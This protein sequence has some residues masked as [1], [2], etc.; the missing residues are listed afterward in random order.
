MN[1]STFSAILCSVAPCLLAAAGA[2]EPAQEGGPLRISGPISVEEQPDPASAFQ[3]AHELIESLGHFPINLEFESQS[4]AQILA[5]T[6]PQDSPEVIE[7]ERVEQPSSNGLP[8]GSDAESAVAAPSEIEEE[9]EASAPI[10]ASELLPLGQS[11]AASADGKTS[12]GASDSN[13]GSIVRTVGATGM[14]IALILLL[15]FAFVKLSGTSGG[16]RAQLGAAGKAPSGVLFVLGRFPISRGMSLVLLQLD[17]RVLLL[18]QTGE[19]FQTLAELTDPD[20]VASIIRKVKD[21]SGESLTAKFGGMLKKFESDPQTIEDLDPASVA[22]PIHLRY[23]ESFA[24]ERPT[25]T[26]GRIGYYES[27]P[28]QTVST[29]EDELRTRINRLREYGA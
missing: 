22:Q 29:G 28:A 3:V 26:S 27:K 11:P 15:R 13:I 8:V 18:S 5:T 4:P 20:E 7:A 16:L 6:P 10:A 2:A 17:Q 12:G 25:G 24:E 14:V 21:E 1:R 23:D 9:P 19:G